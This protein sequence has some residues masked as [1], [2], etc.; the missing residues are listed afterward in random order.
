MGR[1][2]GRPLGA[3]GGMHLSHTVEGMDLVKCFVISG[4]WPRP[5]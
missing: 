5:S 4:T 2:A 1:Q 3:Y